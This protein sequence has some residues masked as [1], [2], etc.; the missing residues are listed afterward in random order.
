MICIQC[1]AGGRAGIFGAVLAVVIAIEGIEWALASVWWIVG[2]AAI[3]IAVATVVLWRLMR[4]AH[5][6]D[7]R[8]R[9][10][11]A[12]R[13]PVLA[14]P[15]LEISGP[16]RRAIALAPVH[17]HFHGLP[18]SEQARIIHQALTEGNDQ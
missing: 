15:R 11:W 8:Y 5:A 16:Q 1:A 2:F 12:E 13:R 18:D 6:R 14:A 7:K 17:I 4:W 10:A 9:E 3:V